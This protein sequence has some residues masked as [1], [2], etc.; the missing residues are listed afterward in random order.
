MEVN[1]AICDDD[2]TALKNMKDK[3]IDMSK[4]LNIVPEIVTYNNGKSVIDM[5]CN[6]KEIYDI[7][8]L[9]IDMSDI[10]GLEVAREIRKSKLD[11]ILIFVSA[12]EQ[13]VFESI[14][15]HPFRYIR[16]NK[17]EEELPLA[18]KAAYS[19]VEQYKDKSIVFKTENGELRLKQNDIMYYET[20]K[21][22][23]RVY[24]SDGSSF[25]LWKTVKGLYQELCDD[26]FI[27]VH[28]G[29]AVNVKYIDEFSSFDITL[30]NGK[31][32]IMSRTRIK[33]VKAA[34]LSY[35]GGKI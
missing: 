27:L 12:H 25:L 7:L 15:Y 23:I 3:I 22:K 4:K 17:I 28:S 11:I 8:F 29:C 32:L 6:K 30:D 35:W 34:I 5:I 19:C 31:H 10:S 2:K 20:E 33:Q 26:N 1:I 9:D 13:Y 18:L 16:K 14:E 21:R 24:M